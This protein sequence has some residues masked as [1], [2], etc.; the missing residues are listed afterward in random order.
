MLNNVIRD[1]FFQTAKARITA[2]HMSVVVALM[3]TIDILVIWVI[4]IVDAYRNI[5]LVIPKCVTRNTH[6][7]C[8]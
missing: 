1:I 3:V 4:I 7:Q 5:K 2:T 8:N 6:I